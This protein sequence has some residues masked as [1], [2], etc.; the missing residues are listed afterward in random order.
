MMYVMRTMLVI[1]ALYNHDL[2]LESDGGVE[3]I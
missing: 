2:L 3:E 1:I